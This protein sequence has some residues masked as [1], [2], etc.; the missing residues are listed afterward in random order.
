MEYVTAAALWLSIQSQQGFRCLEITRG[1]T[2]ETETETNPPPSKTSTPNQ[3]V[4]PV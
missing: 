1:V 2:I 3:Q 4:Q